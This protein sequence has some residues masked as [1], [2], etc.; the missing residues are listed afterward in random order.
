MR[1]SEA[2]LVLL[3]LGPRIQDSPNRI[4][5]NYSNVSLP[6]EDTMQGTYR[7]VNAR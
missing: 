2:N 7:K 1:L 4:P 5:F 6:S 3:A